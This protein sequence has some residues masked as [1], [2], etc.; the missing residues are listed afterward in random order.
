VLS[1]TCSAQVLLVFDTQAATITVV[2][3]FLDPLQD[4]LRREVQ[5]RVVQAWLETEGEACCL[6]VRGVE[7]VGAY[8]R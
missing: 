3:S 5:M 6:P 7:Q 2:D 4:A 1:V 8:S